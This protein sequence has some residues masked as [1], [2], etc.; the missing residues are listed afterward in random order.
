MERWREKANGRPALGLEGVQPRSAHSEQGVHR[1]L[2]T[3]AEVPDTAATNERA[4]EAPEMARGH[5]S[6]QYRYPSEPLPH[7][8][9]GRYRPAGC[10]PGGRAQQDTGPRGA[11]SGKST[12]AK[13]GA[14]DGCRGRWRDDFEGLA[15]PNGENQPWE[16]EEAQL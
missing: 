4:N 6:L 10:R 16:P 8:P 1:D 7:G 5:L 3:R 12:A 13:A 14:M 15:A 9:P 2:G 11:T